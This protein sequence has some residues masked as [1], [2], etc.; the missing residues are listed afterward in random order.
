MASRD[1]SH[2]EGQAHSRRSISVTRNT[3][4]ET[5]A[6]GRSA[7]APLLRARPGIGWTLHPASSIRARMT[8]GR[9]LDSCSWGTDRPA[10]K[11]QSAE[12]SGA[13]SRGVGVKA[14][15]AREGWT[16]AEGRD[17]M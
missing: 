3:Q 1:E 11:L 9:G 6:G 8:E 14:G 15:T 5:R 17:G 7:G 10:S 16:D 2:A 13:I 12:G 4:A